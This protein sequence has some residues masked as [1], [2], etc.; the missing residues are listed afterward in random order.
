MISCQRIPSLNWNK[1]IGELFCCCIND[2]TRAKA[3]THLFSFLLKSWTIST[4]PQILD[5][6]KPYCPQSN[7]SSVPCL[8]Q[9][10]SSSPP[11]DRQNWFRSILDSGQATNSELQMIFIFKVRKEL[12]KTKKNIKNN[13]TI[14]LIL[15]FRPRQ[16]VILPVYFGAR[17]RRY[18]NL[19][20]LIST[21]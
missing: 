17:K 16:E 20:F 19:L 18:L 1:I 10:K 14:K 8:P 5:Y 15:W 7:G 6:I 4:T 21:K 3:Q 9:M 13:F 12:F 2:K 11:W